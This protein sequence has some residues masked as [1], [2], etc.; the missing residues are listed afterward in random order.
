ML[1]NLKPYPAYKD[2][3]VPWL[4]EVPEHWEVLPNRALFEEVKERDY[5]EE[6]LLSVTISQGVIQQTDLLTN[7]SKKDSSNEDKTKYKLVKPGD[8]AY[9]K[10]RAWQGAIGVSRYRGIVSPAY[11][12]VRP[13]GAQNPNYSHYLLRTPDFAKEAE[14]WSYG[15]TSDQWSLRPEHFKMIYCSLPPKDEQSVIVHY[16]DHIDRR[17][18]HYIRAKKKLIKLLEDQKQAIIHQAVTRGLDPNVKLKPSGVEWLGEVPEHWDVVALRRYWE[19]V[20]CK[21]VTVPF[22][23]EGIPLASV[24]EV[25]SFDLN[26]STSKRTNKE[27]YAHLINGGR[28]PKKGD[29]IY[30]RN[31]SVGACA[32][33]TSD[34]TFAMGQDVCLIRSETE[35][36]RFLN[37][38]MRSPAMQ[39][40][41][42]LVLIGSTFHRINVSEIKSLLV[43]VPPRNEQDLIVSSLDASLSKLNKPIELAQREISLLHEYRTRLI[44]DIVTGKLD[45]REAAA[46][47]PEETD[48][49]ETFDD[50][51][52]EDEELENN[53]IENEQAGELEEEVLA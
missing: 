22:V 5:P 23:D 21:H 8:I 34:E 29:L 26:L 14:R 39:Q 4:G 7:S 15:I 50:A 45:V 36:G 6:Q 30:C 44:A 13:R 28:Q 3:G 40:Q 18:R 38:F 53:E 25:Q 20:D 27:W 43:V 32:F 35:N 46:N 33:V 41:L 48:E 49:I 24:R 9:N 42:S 19:V 1:H 16:L 31:V 12:V 47:L 2:S 51:L 11:V 37:Y 10:M 52:A 17:I